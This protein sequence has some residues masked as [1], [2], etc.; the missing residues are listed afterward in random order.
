MNRFQRAFY[1]MVLVFSLHIS[2]QWIEEKHQRYLKDWLSNQYT[3]TG[4]VEQRRAKVAD[5]YRVTAETIRIELR[6]LG[7][8]IE[9]VKRTK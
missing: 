5:R 9:R 2:Y 4:E 1:K 6:E 3:D 8:D 7:V